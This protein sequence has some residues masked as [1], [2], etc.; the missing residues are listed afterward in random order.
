MSGP[1]PE[2][3]PVVMETA[4]SGPPV[5]FFQGRFADERLWL[6]VAQRLAGRHCTVRCKPVRQRIG[7]SLVRTET[8]AACLDK[9]QLSSAHLVSHGS[10][11]STVVE[12]AA[13][14][15]QRVR[16]L[17][18]VDPI[19][20]RTERNP[21]LQEN[22]HVEMLLQWLSTGHGRTVRQP[23]HVAFLRSVIA[24]QTHAYMTPESHDAETPAV[25]HEL[26]RLG[27]PVMALVGEHSLAESKALVASYLGKVRHA[28]TVL[29]P[30]AARHSPLEAPETVARLLGEFLAGAGDRR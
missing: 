2:S 9:L 26:T 24:Q 27:C 15:P 11:W 21:A 16:S 19:I 13:K 30:G 17:A 7:S 6:G 8:V 23:E 14:W 25:D 20:P 10:A 22:W 5:L 12:F 29:V 4:G 1:G 28:R 18:L 3:L